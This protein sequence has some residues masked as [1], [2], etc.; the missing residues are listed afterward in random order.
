MSLLEDMRKERRAQILK[1]TREGLAFCN[2]CDGE[3]TDIQTITI[4]D[5]KSCPHCK[6]PEN[7]TYYH[8]D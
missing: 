8:Q 7:K 1:D 5:E 2:Q 4:E 3:Y 6:N